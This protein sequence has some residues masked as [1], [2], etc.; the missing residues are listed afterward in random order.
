M[1]KEITIKPHWSACLGYRLWSLAGLAVLVFAVADQWHVHTPDIEHRWLMG[2]GFFVC[3]WMWL[4][5]RYH[6]SISYTIRD[7]D[8]VAAAGIVARRSKTIPLAKVRMITVQ[9]TAMQ[10]LFGVAT[11]GLDSAGGAG[12]DIMLRS[13]P[14]PEYVKAEIEKRI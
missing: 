10:R 5:A 2:G 9:D 3:V 6:H 8:I 14:N 1:E 11:I 4:V 13:V 12:G 7:R